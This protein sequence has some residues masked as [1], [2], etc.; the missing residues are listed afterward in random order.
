MEE[1]DILQECK[2]S[3]QKLLSFL[4]KPAVLEELIGLATT[5][6]DNHIKPKKQ[7]STENPP[8]ELVENEALSVLETDTIEES[9]EK[10]RYEKAN[11]ACEL[12]TSD[13]S[14]ITDALICNKELL[15]KLYMFI[16]SEKQLNPLLASFFSKTMSLLFV[17]RSDLLFEFLKT[18]EEFVSHVLKHIETSAVMDFLLKLITGTDNNI[19]RLAISKWLHEKKLIRMLISIFGVNFSAEAQA[20]S[21]QLMCDIIKTIRDYQ[22]SQQ[23]NAE[24]DVLLQDIES[25]S[26][27]AELLNEIFNTRSESSIVSGINVL[28]SLLEYKRH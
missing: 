14:S 22:S 6:P 16:E 28:Q 7:N 12:L 17:K 5:E 1:D 24:P 11:I 8:C 10:T 2:A 19:L 21:A 23:D 13:V 26:T 3:N 15:S 18:K 9:D 4:T 25:T 20:N 27:V